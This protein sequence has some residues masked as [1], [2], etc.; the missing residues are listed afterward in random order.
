ML[1]GYLI[2]SNIIPQK[3]TISYMAQTC[4]PLNSHVLTKFFQS[5]TIPSTLH[6]S[7]FTDKYYP[8]SHRLLIGLFFMTNIIFSISLPNVQPLSL[9]YSQSNPLPN[10]YLCQQLLF[11]FPAN[12]P[13]SPLCTL[14]QLQNSILKSSQIFYT[15][16]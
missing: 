3:D 7:E 10:H 1:T 6:Y 13:T 16:W 15:D 2:S 9:S 14:N 5:A 12:H 4:N 11:S 8:Q